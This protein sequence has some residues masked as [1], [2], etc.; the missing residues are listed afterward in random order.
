MLLG[1]MKYIYEISCL[2]LE[3]K[4]VLFIFFFFTFVRKKKSKTKGC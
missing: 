3:A 1:L 4:G 2:N